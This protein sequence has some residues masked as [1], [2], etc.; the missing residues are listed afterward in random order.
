MRLFK[1]PSIEGFFF[2]KNRMEHSVPVASPIIR[3]PL[4]YLTSGEGV[5]GAYYRRLAITAAIR[6]FIL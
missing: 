3:K 2:D 6:I 5:W 1:N 4:S